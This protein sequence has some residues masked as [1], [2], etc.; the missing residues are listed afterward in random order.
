M[1]YV[2]I[3]FSTSLNKY[4]IGSTSN[5][6]ERLKKHNSNH[7]GFTGGTGDWQIVWQEIHSDKSIA[8]KRE[9]QIKKWKS[10]KMIE[11]LIAES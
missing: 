11:S 2:Y 7:K 6:K 5:M 8:M 1:Y 10:R 4:Y 9:R 3:L